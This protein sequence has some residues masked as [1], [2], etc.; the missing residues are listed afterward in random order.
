MVDLS[1]PPTKYPCDHP[2]YNSHSDTYDN[3]GD[4]MIVVND[5]KKKVKILHL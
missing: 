2:I 3:G 5:E 1:K 4:N